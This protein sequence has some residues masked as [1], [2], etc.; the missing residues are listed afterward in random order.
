MNEPEVLPKAST[1][2]RLLRLLPQ[3]K[4]AMLL[5]ARLVPMLRELGGAN[6]AS[7]VQEIEGR[8]R[9]HLQQSASAMDQQ[10][11]EVRFRLKEQTAATARLESDLHAIRDQIT[12]EAAER[13]RL[14]KRIEAME[15]LLKQAVAGIVLCVL[16][17]AVVV[18]VLLRH[19]G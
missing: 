7:S 5:I 8:L 1:G 2:T 13:A 3:G 9:S 17:L 15:R 4:Q 10:A 14:Q 18:I 11:E 16:L 19:R 12:R 6:A